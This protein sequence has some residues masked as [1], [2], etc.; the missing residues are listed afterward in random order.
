M[1]WGSQ[2][3]KGGG[4]FIGACL[5]GV[6]D[7]S[8]VIRDEHRGGV[9]RG[10][11]SVLFQVEGCVS[12]CFLRCAQYPSPSARYTQVVSNLYFSAPGTI[13]RMFWARFFLL[14]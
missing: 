10:F 11:G 13:K 6:V 4:E 8:E 12:S 3:P 2:V 7:G 5:R 14:F 1:K 9:D